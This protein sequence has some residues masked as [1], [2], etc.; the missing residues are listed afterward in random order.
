MVS[1]ATPLDI[2]DPMNLPD[3]WEGSDEPLAND[4]HNLEQ[5]H[6]FSVLYDMFAGPRCYVSFQRW[7]RRDPLPRLQPDILVALDRPN[8]N[9]NEYDS[10]LEGKPP[11]LL[12]EWLSPRSQASDLIAKPDAYAKMGVREYWVFNPAGQYPGPRIQG[13]TLRGEA[14]AQ[15]LAV[16]E[17]GSIA[18]QILPVKFRIAGDVLELLHRQTG[19]PLT[20][21]QAVKQQWHHEM[22]L[23]AAAQEAAA[24][25][26]EAAAA[27]EEAATAA[28]RREA[29]TRVR[30]EAEI[31]RLQAELERLRREHEG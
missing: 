1:T 14:P 7:L 24:A 31:R 25:A 22:E 10:R 27:A 23:R 5:I 12:A 26:Q 28:L 30:A 16:A 8:Y 2:P 21:V 18:S 11:D 4:Y 3:D 15:S 29:E 13:W 6:C 19:E 9:R 20:E 17:D